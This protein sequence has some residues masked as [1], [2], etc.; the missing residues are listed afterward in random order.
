MSDAEVAPQKQKGFEDQPALK[1]NLGM[2]SLTFMGVGSIIGSGWLFGAYNAS[3]IAGP[4]ALFSWLIGGV[5]ILAIGLCFAELGPMFPVSGGVVRYPH[6]TWGSLASFA[7]GFVMWIA[8]AATPAIEV[9]AVLTYATKFAPFTEAVT[10]ASGTTAHVLTPMGIGVGIVLM[11]VFTALNFFGVKLFA[12]I[13]DGLVWW[14]LAMIVLVVVVFL[15]CALTTTKMGTPANFTS[16]GFAPKGF[17]AVLTAV[18]TAGIVFAYTGFR[19]PIELAGESKNPK[20]NI[21]LAIILSIAIC[22]LIYAGLQ[23]AFTIGVPTDLLNE[24]GSWAGLK[25][26]DDFGPLAALSTLAGLSFLAVLLY[27]DAIIS[28]ADTGLIF[29]GVAARISYALSRNGNAPRVLG[30]VSKHGV[31]A[32]SLVFTFVIGCVLLMPFPSWQQ[33]VG[34][35]TSGSVISF[36]AGPL[37]LAALRR[38]MPNHGRPFRLPG[39]DALPL[40]AFFFANMIVYWA[41]WETNSKLFIAIVVGFALLGLTYLFGRGADHMSALH[42]KHGIWAVVW[43]AGLAAISFFMDAERNAGADPEATP[44]V[45][46]LAMPVTAVFSVVIFYWAQATMLPQEE[47]E[48]RVAAFEHEAASAKEE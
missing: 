33:M 2:I 5:M 24:A 1:R 36:A 48:E 26:E 3:M 22:A 30:T 13:N 35:I 29:T 16:H 34:F 7:V 39:G 27:I 45:F 20:R 42:A 8:A 44:L 38:R 6:L 18:A 47:V 31:P 14:K 32:A 25:F 46:W 37:V 17:A 9:E 28:P 11:A 4:A 15:F 23:V 12:R 10:S 19:Q 40:I 41:G 43:L 21:P